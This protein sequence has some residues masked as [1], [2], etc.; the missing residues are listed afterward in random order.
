MASGETGEIPILGLCASD[1]FDDEED[2]DGGVALADDYVEP[3]LPDPTVVVDSSPEDHATSLGR[4]DSNQLF[5]SAD[6]QVP[7]D[8]KQRLLADSVSNSTAL[9][10]PLGSSSSSIG[11]SPDVRQSVL[12][13]AQELRPGL[14]PVTNCFSL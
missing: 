3:D 13:R 4:V 6:S 11:S 5:E 10:S 1:I 8:K 7:S 9:P 14:L 2:D 12:N